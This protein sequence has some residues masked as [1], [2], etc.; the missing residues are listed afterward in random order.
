MGS[1]TVLIGPPA[2]GKSTLGVLLAKRLSD[3]FVDTD[4]L[5]QVR[6]GRRLQ[7]ILDEV[8]PADFRRLEEEAVLSL[9]PRRTVVATGGSVVYGERA[10]RHLQAT[11]RII[12]LRLPL[13]EW[14][15]RLRDLDSRGVV[16]APGQ[17][18]ESLY[19]EREPLYRR[20]A[21]AVVDVAALGAAEAV[22]RIVA[23]RD[24]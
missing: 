20:W 6:H 15:R 7:E 18:L 13:G 21:D 24:V 22:E 23:A 14:L 8:G 2:A 1:N 3:D 9:A 5:L 12:Y 19:A 16:R 10:M 4:V 11:S 17:S